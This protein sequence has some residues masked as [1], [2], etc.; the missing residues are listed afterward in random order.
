M[1]TRKKVTEL[2]SL[3]KARSKEILTGLK[4]VDAIRLYYTSRHP[5]ELSAKQ[6]EIHVRY[7][8]AYTCQLEAVPNMEIVSRMKGLFG[9]AENQ[10]FRDIRESIKVFGDASRPEKEGI[11]MVVLEWAKDIYQNARAE[12]DWKEANASIRNIINLMG[13]DRD[14]PDMPDFDK[15]SGGVHPLVLDEPVRKL[16]LNLLE[17]GS[18][19][20]T[21]LLKQATKASN[22]EDIG[23]EEVN[24]IGADKEGN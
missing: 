18:V 15:I 8:Y 22:I 20:I 14:D 5:I 17:A 19:D 10:A 7:R 2:T 4:A 12:K 23:Y 1:K 13:L 21:S 6:E 11:R 9:I 16:L 3:E 24:S